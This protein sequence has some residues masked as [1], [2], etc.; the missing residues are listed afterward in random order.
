VTVHGPQ[1]EALGVEA[2]L[3]LLAG[4]L[5]TRLPGKLMRRVGG[6]PLLVRVYRRL[7]PLGIPCVLSVREPLPDDVAS[8]IPA[9]QVR[10]EEHGAGPLAGLSAAAAAVRT[11]YLFAVAGDLP[12]IEPRVLQALAQRLVR[13]SS[14]GPAPQAVVPRHSNGQ[15][16]PLAALYES[17]ALSA[18]ARRVLARGSRRVSDVLAEMR[19]CYHPISPDDETCYRNVNTLADWEALV[20][21]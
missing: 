9:P 12:D 16:E 5:A 1:S 20:Q 21:A 13:E 14:P 15:I 3:V 17:A 6:V 10:D 8:L 4:G 11:A 2:S 7:A 19:T 18:A